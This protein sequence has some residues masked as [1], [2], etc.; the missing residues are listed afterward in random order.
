M[1]QGGKNQNNAAERTCKEHALHAVRRTDRNQ[2]SSHGAGRTGNLII[3]AR[4]QRNDNS[5]DDGG[6]KTGSGI[7]A[8][9]YAER[10]RKRQRN[11]GNR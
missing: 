5:C 9:R 11:G 1:E 3:A 6:D 8:G 10:K 4:E 7:R 2:N